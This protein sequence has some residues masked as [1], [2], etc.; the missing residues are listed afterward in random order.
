VNWELTPSA[1]F[2][3]TTADPAFREIMKKLLLC[4]LFVAAVSLRADIIPTFAGASSSQDQQSTVWS[5][6]I[7][8]TDEQNANPGDFFTIYD[9]SSI[10]PVG[11]SAPAGWTFSAQL[12]GVTASQTN[13]NDDISLYNLTWTYNGPTIIG[14]SPDGKNIGPFSVTTPGAFDSEFPPTMRDG[15]FTARGTRAQGPNAG[16]GVSNIGIVPVPAAIPEPSTIALIIGAGGLGVVG[17]AMARR[18]R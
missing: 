10:A 16:S 6:T 11:L 5:Y 1:Q 12:V 2:Y 7:N 15:Q 13:P 3:K 18:R 17:R 9:F 8:V 4:V 14:N